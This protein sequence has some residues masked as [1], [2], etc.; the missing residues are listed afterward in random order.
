MSIYFN[1]NELTNMTREEHLAFCKKCTNREMDLKQG[2][3]CALT[4]EKANFINDCRDFVLDPTYEER[5][6]DTEELNNQVV[7]SLI[8][9]KVLE[10]LRV[11]QNFPIGLMSG[12]FVG[13][14]GAL[15][16]GAITLATGYQIG[17]V[18]LAIGAGVGLSIRYAGKGVDQIFGITGA[19]VAVLSCFLGNFFSIIGTIANLENLEYIETLLL[20][21]Y[22]LLIP[23]MQ[24]TFS[25][26][27]VLFYGIAGYEGYKFAFR[28][29]TEKELEDLKKK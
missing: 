14:I 18:A 28:S 24:E 16:W 6:D 3:V 9:D 4:K 19:I 20:F 5:F 1:N 26:M 17:Y 8:S 23:M 27:D 15:L 2:L 22:S 21:D 12:I 7:K 13:I 11:E 29:F 25:A 10:K